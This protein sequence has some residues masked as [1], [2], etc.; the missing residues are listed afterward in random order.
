LTSLGWQEHTTKKDLYV[1]IHDKVY[2]SSSF[3]DEHPCVPFFSLAADNFPTNTTHN[4]VA[5]KKSS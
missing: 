1:V 4:T 5:A 2:D 3:V